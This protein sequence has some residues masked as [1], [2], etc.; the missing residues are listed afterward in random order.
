MFKII[1]FAVLFAGCVASY[2]VISLQ[3][4][5]FACLVGGIV[6]GVFLYSS[7]DDIYHID[8]SRDS[9]ELYERGE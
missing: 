8:P 1:V 6:S 7:I 2:L 3:I 5:G 9:N 4:V